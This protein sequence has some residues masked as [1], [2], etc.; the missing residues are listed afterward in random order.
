M[1]PNDPL[2]AVSR[3]VALGG[4]D[5]DR[6]PP[7]ARRNVQRPLDFE[8]GRDDS[9]D[10]GDR[11]LKRTRTVSVAVSR[12][13]IDSDQISETVWRRD[14]DIRVKNATIDTVTVGV[15]LSGV[16]VSLMWVS[17]LSV[18]VRLAERFI[19]QPSTS[20]VEDECRHAYEV[21]KDERRDYT[22]CV[23][24]QTNQCTADFDRSLATALA[25]MRDSFATNE[26]ALADY[27]AVQAACSQ[28]V[29]FAQVLFLRR[30]PHSYTHT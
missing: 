14:R 28:A 4:G 30:Q 3:V 26:A 10:E 24:L 16:A 27:E 21:A 19:A 18:A 7:A 5:A 20:L 8:S 15:R 17:S 6:T 25:Q 29:T 13:L 9:R 1:I 2:V 22:R 11:E 23:E 12:A